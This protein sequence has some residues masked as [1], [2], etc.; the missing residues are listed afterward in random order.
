[1]LFKNVSGANE[2]NMTISNKDV[3]EIGGVKVMPGESR[4][5]DLFIAKFYDFTDVFMPVKV[6]RGTEDGPRLFVCAALHGDEINGVEIIKRLL[7]VKRLRKLKGTLIAIPI[8]NVFGFNNMSRY[9]PDRRDLN[10]C[11]PGSSTGS[12][13][14]R[15]ARLFETEIL[16]KCTVG[17]DLHTGSR[18]RKNLPQVR[19]CLKDKT[20]AHLAENF[21]VPVILNAEI[22][23]GSLRKVAFEKRIPLLVFE[24][25]EPLRYDEVAIRSGLSGVLKVMQTLG[26]IPDDH[27]KTPHISSFTANG[28]YW[29]RAPHSGIHIIKKRL[30]SVIEADDLLGV[31]S[32]PLGRDNIEVRAKEKGIIISHTQLPLVNRGD[33]LFHVATFER[34]M[35]VSESIEQFDDKFDYEEK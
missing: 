19:A 10:R 24:G 30:G 9:L 11:F 27:K 18:H 32:D 21:G 25:G 20:T 34:M 5:I 4:N 1:M 3:L 35:K 14:S 22:I 23:D 8:V 28:H 17:I 16:D 31:I 6:I 26:M 13:A 7:A 15:L 33:A 12:M 2:R 29:E